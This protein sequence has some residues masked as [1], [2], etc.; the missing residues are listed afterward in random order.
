MR[1][2]REEFDA[3]YVDETYAMFPVPDAQRS[4]VEMVA[5]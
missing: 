5:I 2:A 1:T 4:N 3:D